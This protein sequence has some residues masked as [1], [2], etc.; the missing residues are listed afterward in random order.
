MHTYI[1]IYIYRIYLNRSPGFY[2]FPVSFDPACI[3]AP[4]SIKVHDN[5]DT[6]SF[7]TVK[8]EINSRQVTKQLS[9]NVSIERRHVSIMTNSCSGPG[10]YSGPASIRDQ[11]LLKIYPSDPRPLFEPWLLFEPGFYTDIY[12]IHMWPQNREWAQRKGLMQC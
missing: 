10:H 2:F 6:C 1:Y 4:T 8:C 11:L 5:L 7:A 3:R 12:G 9:T